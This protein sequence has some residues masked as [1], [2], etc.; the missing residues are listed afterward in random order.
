[1]GG[2]YGAGAMRMKVS[3]ELIVHLAR[4]FVFVMRIGMRGPLPLDYLPQGA[5]GT[6]FHAR[7]LQ[8]GQRVCE[9]PDITRLAEIYLSF[10]SNIIFGFASLLMYRR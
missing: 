5:S 10:I 7:R 1:M 4:Q 3:C 2:V 8:T 6:A 9:F